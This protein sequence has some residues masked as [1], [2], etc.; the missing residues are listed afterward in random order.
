MTVRTDLNKAYERKVIGVIKEVVRKTA[1]NIDTDLVNMT[2]V[3]TGRAESNWLPSVNIPRGDTV[4]VG[5]KTAISPIIANV[6]IDDT[7]YIAN[8]LPYIQRLNSG[9]SSQ[10]TT[11]SW[12]E[13]AVQKNSAH[14][15]RVIKEVTHGL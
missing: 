15:K 3:D 2:P 14:M 1:F 7:I 9:W 11:P 12:V 5:G 6:G 8:N 13:A 10:N 4:G